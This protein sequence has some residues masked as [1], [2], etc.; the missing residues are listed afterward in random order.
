M[1]DTDTQD[2]FNISYAPP[3][4]GMR[5]NA[6]TADMLPNYI[7]SGRLKQGGTGSQASSTLEDFNQYYTPEYDMVVDP[8]FGADTG[9]MKQILVGFKL[10]PDGQA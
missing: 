5:D 9:Q 3:A 6:V 10:S 1:V 7:Y 2:Q 4:D 8:I